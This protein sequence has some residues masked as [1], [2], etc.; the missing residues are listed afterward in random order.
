MIQFP[1]NP[2]LNQEYSYESK[3]WIWDGVSWNL[4]PFQETDLICF[5][6][7]ARK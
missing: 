7:R 3:T 6:K 2:I 5:A 1:I 4:K